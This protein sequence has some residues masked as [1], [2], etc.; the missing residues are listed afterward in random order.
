[1]YQ[2]MDNVRDKDMRQEVRRLMRG[3]TFFRM[4]LYDFPFILMD[5]GGGVSIEN[6]FQQL[7]KSVDAAQKAAGRKSLLGPQKR[8]STDTAID[9]CNAY[10]TAVFSVP[11]FRELCRNYG[12]LES[13]DDK[14]NKE[15]L[16]PQGGSFKE[17]CEEVITINRYLIEEKY[18]H[19]TT[20][21][22]QCPV[23][24]YMLESD[25]GIALLRKVLG[26]ENVRTIGGG[27]VQ[28]M[29]PRPHRGV[30]EEQ[31]LNRLAGYFLSLSG[32]T[33]PVVSEKPER[34]NKPVLVHSVEWP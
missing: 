22:D 18:L 33:E 31:A 14:W 34:A 2:A 26:R 16:P 19:I 15:Y 25:E 21:I 29:K 4:G 13:L 12:Y 9:P 20:A 24:M 7:V 8:L 3:Y 23:W 1:M 28:N 11:R 32:C 30:L 5:E 27:L 6:P 17:L 10:S